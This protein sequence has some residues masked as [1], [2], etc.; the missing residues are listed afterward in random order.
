[1]W[2]TARYKSGAKARGVGDGCPD[3]IAKSQKVK[4]RLGGRK[5][6]EGGLGSEC[7]THLTQRDVLKWNKVGRKKEAC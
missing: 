5:K 2:A 1:M 4:S 7:K 3:A 6:V